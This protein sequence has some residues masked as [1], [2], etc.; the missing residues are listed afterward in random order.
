MKGSSSGFS[1]TL[2]AFVFVVLVSLIVGYLA[3]RCAA[4]RE[5]SAEGFANPSCNVCGQSRPKCGCSAPRKPNCG[6]CNNPKPSCS[7]PTFTP[8][9]MPNSAAAAIAAGLPPPTMANTIA[10][11]K[12]AQRMRRAL[13]SADMDEVTG[14]EMMNNASIASPAARIA[15]AAAAAPTAPSTCPMP[16]PSK[17]VLKS[18]IPPCPPMPD[19][20]RYMLKT[21]CPPQP[22]MSKYVL[23]SSVPKCPPCISSC[24]KPCKI[25]ECPPCPRPRCP[26]VRCPDPKPCPACPAVQ[27]APCAEPKVQC[28]A[29]YEP[30]NNVRPML[31][32]T[33]TFGL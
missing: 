11:K 2:S 29:A 25:G 4:T 23:K 14:P 31:A 15:M 20:S 28:K 7:C 19:M 30:Q 3:G 24:S 32:S 12:K 13:Q 1:Y 27:V 21:E 22:D 10:A 6:V 16:D 26:V 5:L 8:G 18:T 17:Y 33:S 9:A